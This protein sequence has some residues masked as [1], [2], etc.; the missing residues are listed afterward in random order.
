MV[1]PI[2]LKTNLESKSKLF[3]HRQG[4]TTGIEEF[5]ILTIQLAVGVEQ[6]EVRSLQLHA[7]TVHTQFLSNLLREVVG[8]GNL[9]E[10]DEI[11]L[12]HTGRGIVV[13]VVGTVQVFAC[14]RVIMILPF[15]GNDRDIGLCLAKAASHRGCS[16][17]P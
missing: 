17:R 4:H 2:K 16:A 5:R 13:G 6:E 8:Q 14:F 9:L 1:E 15:T 11:T 7:Q 3:C 10:T 12:C